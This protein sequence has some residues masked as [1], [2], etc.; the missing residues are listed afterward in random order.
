MALPRYG[1]LQQL[2]IIFDYIKKHHNT[3]VVFDPTKPD[4]DKALFDRQDCSHPVYANGGTKLEEAQ[5]T[6]RPKARGEGF[7]MR[8]Y[9]ESGHAGNSTTRITR[10]GFLVYLKNVLIYWS[11][12][13]QML[14]ETSLF[15]NEFIA[16]K[17][18]TEYVRG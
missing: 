6:G 2:C 16:M 15:G 14:V 3:E 18:G 9:I 4:I 11:S 10:M 8:L 7:I 5:P 12:K 1:H 13:K 17:T